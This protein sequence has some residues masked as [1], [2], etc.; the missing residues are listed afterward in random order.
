MADPDKAAL[1]AG[2]RRPIAAGTTLYGEGL[3]SLPA[4]RLSAFACTVVG[5]TL[6]ARPSA[7][8]RGRSGQLARRAEGSTI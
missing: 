8:E 2:G 6:L 3:G 7:D 4:L 1:A 5:A